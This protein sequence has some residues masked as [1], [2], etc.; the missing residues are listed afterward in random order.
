M[1][2]LIFKIIWTIIAVFCVILTIFFL[3]ES[4][5]SGIESLRSVFSDGFF[6]GIKTFFVDIW[7]GFKSTVG[8]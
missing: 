4:D 2:K 1:V 5:G 7:N 6:N 3:F 8:L